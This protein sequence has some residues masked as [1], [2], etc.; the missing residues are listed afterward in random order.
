MDDRP[1]RPRRSGWWASLMRVKMKVMDSDSFEDDLLL[2]N[3]TIQLRLHDT[4]PPCFHTVVKG[5]AG[6]LNDC[7]PFWRAVRKSA[8]ASRL[9][10]A[11]CRP[12]PRTRRS[13]AWHRLPA[14]GR[15]LFSQAS[16]AISGH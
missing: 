10:A 2:T 1:G 13:K 8:A 7:E 12:T 16:T 15:R 6:K 9:R 3:D 11:A 14:I 4:S 5:P